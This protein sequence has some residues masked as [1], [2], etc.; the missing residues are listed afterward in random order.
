MSGP[1]L[2]LLALAAMQSHSAEE[3]GCVTAVASEADRA[4]IASSMAAGSPDAALVDRMRE[5]AVAC[6]LRFGW[7][8]IRAGRMTIAAVATVA[9]DRYAAMLAERDVD[10]ALI[11][12]WLAAESETERTDLRFDQARG[13][14]IVVALVQ[15]GIPQATLESHGRLVGQYV[16]ALIAL[17]RLRLGLPIE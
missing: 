6:A 5:S 8:E 4:L 13:E 14:R 1:A 12:R 17:E 7:D 11:R 16:A 2:L 15:A 9:R 3:L 10:T